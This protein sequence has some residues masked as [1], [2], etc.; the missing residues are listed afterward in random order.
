[1]EKKIKTEWYLELQNVHGQTRLENVRWKTAGRATRRPE[2]M[3]NKIR[4]A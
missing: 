3:R 2:E 1:M 4:K